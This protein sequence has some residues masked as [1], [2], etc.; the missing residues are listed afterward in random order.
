MAIK[1]KLNYLIVNYRENGLNEQIGFRKNRACIDHI[2]VLSSVVRA[3][4]EKG[5]STFA[6]FVDFK[7][8]FDCVNRN[9]LLFKLLS[10]GINGKF[11]NAIKSL[12]KDPI[13]CVRVNNLRKVFPTPFGV[14][15][16]DFL[17]PSLFSFYQCQLRT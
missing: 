6:C 1:N 11:Y 2:Y 13:A 9:L 14:K 12:F 5:G 15:Q 3:R 4:V 16:S 17:S 7:K 8:A 10:S